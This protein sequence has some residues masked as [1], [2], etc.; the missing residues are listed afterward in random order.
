MNWPQI[1]DET[2]HL[3]EEGRSLSIHRLVLGFD[4]PSEQ[5]I[6]SDWLLESLRRADDLDNESV[7]PIPSDDVMKKARALTK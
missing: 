7:Q 5:A 6:K 3:P 2:P 1:E 4:S